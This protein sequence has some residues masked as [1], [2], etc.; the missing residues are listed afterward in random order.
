MHRHP[1]SCPGAAARDAAWTL[2]AL[3]NR[4]DVE[5]VGLLTTVTD[6]YERIA[7]HGIAATSCWRRPKRPDCP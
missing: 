1:S 5:V 3:R 2:H 6:G 4:D 7:M